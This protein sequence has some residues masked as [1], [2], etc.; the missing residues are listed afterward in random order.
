MTP[1]SVDQATKRGSVT[2]DQDTKVVFRQSCRERA[3]PSEFPH[4]F[5][6]LRS[7]GGLGDSHTCQPPRAMSRVEDMGRASGGAKERCVS[8]G[9]HSLQG[10]NVLNRILQPLGETA[11]DKWAKD[12][13]S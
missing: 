11:E 7:T 6:D 4:F 13:E 5:H 3:W 10:T 8:M 2:F 9:E 1:G 12:V